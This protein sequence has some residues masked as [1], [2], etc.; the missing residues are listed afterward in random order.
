M[1]GAVDF[2]LF[3][4]KLSTGHEKNDNG[5]L[6]QQL[7][8]HISKFPQSHRNFWFLTNIYMRVLIIHVCGTSVC[9]A[10]VQ[11]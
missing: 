1:G 10:Y 6:N 8:L 11:A 7:A 3:L 4:F 9:T 2:H 5:R